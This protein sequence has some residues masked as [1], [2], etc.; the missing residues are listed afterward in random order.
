[1]KANA[2]IQAFFSEV[3]GI[4]DQIR[5]YGDSIQDERMGETIPRNFPVKSNHVVDTIEEFKH[6]PTL[7]LHELMDSLEARAK[8]EQFCNSDLGT[9]I[10]HPSQFGRQKE[11]ING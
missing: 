11:C 2:S 4:I 10:P 8:F 5:S 6:L 9:N 7:T 3:V 1:M